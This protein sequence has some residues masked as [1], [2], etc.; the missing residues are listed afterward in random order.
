MVKRELIKIIKKHTA[1]DLSDPEVQTC[2]KREL[3]EIRGIYYKVLNDYTKFTL[4]H[5]GKSM[6]K[7]HA[8][9]LHAVKNF[10]FWL[11]Y[12][13]RLNRKYKDILEDFKKYIGINKLT[14]KLTY[15]IEELLNNYVKLKEQYD[16]LKSL[17]TEKIDSDDKP[18]AL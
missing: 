8:T 3:V 7:T 5:V 2:R 13:E 12:D 16:E 6:G 15:N 1:I 10:D 18:L 17:V 4:E 14:G 11:K 9:V